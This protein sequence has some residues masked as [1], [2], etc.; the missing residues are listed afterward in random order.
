MSIFSILKKWTPRFVWTA[1][2]NQRTLINARNTF[3]SIF[4]LQQII[5]H[6]HTH[7]HACTHTP[8]SQT[9]TCTP[10]IYKQI[11][12][13]TC[14]RTHTHTHNQ[15]PTLPTKM[16]NTN[17]SLKVQILCSKWTP[18]H[19]VF[20]RFDVRWQFD[21]DLHILRAL[22]VWITQLCAIMTYREVSI[23]CCKLL[24]SQSVCAAQY[25]ISVM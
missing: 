3:R 22:L 25:V 9:H 1:A 2:S 11:H 8:H 21:F 17:N 20:L 10:H 7:T 6:T 18:C 23:S 14:A 19:T 16:T 5:T 13:H 12:L 15:T 4:T 24:L